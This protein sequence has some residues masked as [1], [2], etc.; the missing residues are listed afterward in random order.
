MRPHGNRSQVASK[1]RSEKKGLQRG[2]SLLAYAFVCASAVQIV[3]ASAANS[4]EQQIYDFNIPAKNAE[5]ALKDVARLT[6]HSLLFQ[7]VEVEQTRTNAI[8][9]SYSLDEA[10]SILFEGT[11]LAG[12]LTEN[13]VITVALASGDEA[14]TREAKVS[15]R[16]IKGLL[17]TVSSA[18]L[19]SVTALGGSVQWSS[20]AY[21]QE[22]NS[23]DEIIVTGSR[24]ARSG[25][26][27]PTPTIVL[28]SEAISASGAVNIGD[29]L[30]EIPA[31]GP[32]L[33]ADSTAPT[34]SGAGLN[35]VD[36]RRLGTER[37]LVLVNG[38]RQVG[39]QPGTTAVDLNTIPTP[40]V[41]RVDV[42]TGGA[43]AVYGADA[44]SG[45]V[46]FVLKDDFEGLELDVQGGVSDEGDAEQFQVS[47]T[48]GAISGD[49]RGRAVF[50]GSYSREG[51]IEFDQR[52]TAISGTNWLPNPANTG[53]NDG[54]PDFVLTP[55]VRQLG[56][57][58][59]AAFIIN[60][61]SGPEVY[62]FNPD[63]SVRPFALG[64][65]G[66]LPGNLT[67]GGEAPLGFD[68][69]CPQNRCQLKVPVERFLM[70]GSAEYDIL[71]KVTGYFT[72][73]FANSQS[74][75]RIGSVF[76]IPPF[77]NDIP[78]DNPFVTDE[79]RD[80]H[81]AAGQDSVQI[82]RSNTELGPRGTDSD[83]RQFQMV[84]G[85]KG[86][87]GDWGGTSNWSYDTHFQYG[88]TLVTIIRLNDLFQNRFV[89]ALDAVVDPSDGQIRCRSVVEGTAQ[90]PGCVPINLLQSGASLTPEAQTFVR[91]PDPTETA[92]LQQLVA[93]GTLTGNL[94]DPFGAGEIGVAVGGEWRQE[95][96]SFTPAATQAGTPRGLTGVIP[97]RMGP[98]GSVTSSPGGGLGFFNSTRR[99]ISGKFT[100]YEF[101]GETLVPVLRDQPF[102]H[103]LNV[104]AAVRYAN[105]S[106]SGSATSWKFGGD[107]AP[108]PDIRFRG[109]R[110]RAVRAP[111]VGELF[112]PGTEGFVTVDDPC[113]RDFVGGGSGSRAANCAALGISPT[114]ESNARTINIRTAFSGNPELE[115]EV[116]DTWTVGAVL[117]PQGLPNF[118]MTVDYYSIEI[119]NAINTLGTQQVLDS[120]VDL[121][122]TNN[123]FCENVTRD[124][125]GNLLL[126]QT[127][128]LN[129]S[130]FTREGIDVEARY[131]LDLGDYGVVTISGVANRVLTNETVLAPGTLTGSDIID[132][133]GQIGDPKWR[134]RATTG[135]RNGPWGLTTTV[136]FMSNQVPD[137]TPATPEDNRAT[138][139]TGGFTLVDLQAQYD[140]T[141]GATLRAGVDNVFDNLPP[142]LPDTR[143]GG[144]GS[145][146]GAE[147]F[148]ITGR[149]F[150][151]GARVRF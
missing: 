55:N 93:S 114:F 68:T 111:N 45:V 89:Q 32:G 132:F 95:S 61:A 129:V 3:D 34:F 43:S 18:V 133:N 88:S 151:V 46:N 74:E 52:D 139:G 80:L 28:D 30:R 124:A 6:R 40:L 117:T 48:G 14:E 112:S 59:E 73:S 20:P 31:I 145:F 41:E 94:F 27:T 29:L 72:G 15:K 137:I 7:T 82:V 8:S 44:V 105:Y 79:V 103:Q 97:Q 98:G 24:I 116:A 118:S 78:L 62:G 100:V 102:A 50:H 96:S 53:P 49:G 130:S 22:A 10:I 127:R 21:A 13:G 107:W 123:V 122:T 81:I 126:V 77:T 2:C 90:D 67:D 104:E 70:Y 128:N 60:G 9:G 35:L 91:I 150:Y 38:R 36:L 5:A 106:T 131:N 121:D 17:T 39:S 71:D 144:A 147:I 76:E 83:R 92:E 138:T 146:G 1:L 87:L 86:D 125:S 141:D 120:C 85:A 101:F 19:T 149:F 119:E 136:S 64:P 134:T 25:T 16:G 109:V 143:Q 75:S 84:V 37:T 12:G 65:S 26:T 47:L 113:D 58:Q 140:V 23:D 54:I 57:Q 63:G 135:W 99:A 4:S 51:S 108:T 56:G 33:N 69:E 142:N 11:N 115:V 110:S 66:L 148:P 42:I